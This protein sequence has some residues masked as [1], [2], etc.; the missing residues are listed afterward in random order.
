MRCKL[1]LFFAFLLLIGLASANLTAGNF[2]CQKSY[3]SQAKF[4]GWVNI[5]FTDHPINDSFSDNFGNSITISEILLLN[6]NYNYTLDN[7][8]NTINSSS[9]KLYFD[10]ASFYLPSTF[11]K[12][13]LYK[14]AISNVTVISANISISNAKDL[15]LT[16]LK[17]KKLLLG[18]ITLK[19]DSYPLFLRVKINSELGIS[20]IQGNLTNIESVYN[21]TNDYDALLEELNAIQ[22]PLSL[23]ESETASLISFIP[24]KSAI[25][26]DTL[27]AIGGGTYNSDSEEQY[28]DQIIFWAEENL[29]PKITFKKINVQYADYEETL[30]TYSE[31]SFDSAP[32]NVFFIIETIDGLE[33]GGNYNS[34]TEGDYT[35]IDLSNTNKKII[36]TTS[37]NLGFDSIPAF[38]SPSLEQIT[39]SGEDIIDSEKVEKMSKWILFSLVII[40]LLIIFIISYYILH[41]WYR[42][43]YENYLFPN[44]NNLYNLIVYINNAQK[45]GVK[46][47][48]IEKSLRKAKWTNEQIKYVMKKYAGKRTGMWSPF[49][50]ENTQNNHTK[51][52]KP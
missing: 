33:F 16:E 18:N 29:N 19:I 12:N 1:V 30:L 34:Q 48:E 6:P 51:F 32:Q 25:N 9:G 23:A 14:I 52:N 2:S 13:L 11:V 35:Y 4:L 36:F 31:I 3:G 28:K 49:F 45:K 42:K 27:Q 22:I 7:S 21:N 43:K 10:N 40:L 46:N 17:E 39:V 5:N 8:T 47:D 50:K 37:E 44:R 38:I 24:E 20:K 41:S 15:I 26:L